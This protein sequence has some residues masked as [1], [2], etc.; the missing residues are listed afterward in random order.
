MEETEHSHRKTALRLPYSCIRQFI[1]PVKNMD[2]KG[3][4]ELE[5]MEFRAYHG[6][7]EKERTEGNDFVVDFR[8]EMYMD[9]AAESDSLDDALNYA[10]IY[11]AVAEEMKIPSDLLEHVA[12]RIV[13]SIAEKFPQ[14]LSFSVRVSKSRPPVDG[15]VKWSRI[16]LSHSSKAL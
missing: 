16:T 11:D 2:K 5:G 13:K 15:N 4:L 9:A 3:I 10:L 14:L 6:C 8:G 1:K 12:G 7:L